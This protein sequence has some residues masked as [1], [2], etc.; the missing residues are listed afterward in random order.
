MLPCHPFPFF[1]PEKLRLKPATISH[2]KHARARSRLQAGNQQ[3]QC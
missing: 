1:N 3:T 2:G